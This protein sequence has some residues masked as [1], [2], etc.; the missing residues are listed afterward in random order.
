VREEFYNKDKDNMRDRITFAEKKMAERGVD[1]FKEELREVIREELQNPANCSFD[2]VIKALWENWNVETRV[3]GNTISYRHPEYRDK[4][5]NLVSVRGSKLGDLYTVKGIKYEYSKKSQ[6][7][8]HENYI[9]G[10]EPTS[11]T[12]PVNERPEPQG[13]GG[14]ISSGTADSDIRGIVQS[15]DRFYER[16]RKPVKDDER[17]P[18]KTIEPPKRVRNQG[19]R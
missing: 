2:D 3:A 8:E 16:Y 6:S 5:N 4:N 18:V 12:I 17:E 7:R 10:I 15:V 1:S 14:Q 13:S 9:G 19:A 11:R